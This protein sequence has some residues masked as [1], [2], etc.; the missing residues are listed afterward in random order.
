[1]K[2]YKALVD[3]FGLFQDRKNEFAR[4]EDYDSKKREFKFGLM[5]F[6]IEIPESH[7]QG[8]LILCMWQT[9]MVK[10]ING[11]EHPLF[12]GETG[13]FIYKPGT[14]SLKEEFRTADNIRMWEGYQE[15]RGGNNQHLS[16]FHKLKPKITINYFSDFLCFFKVVFGIYKIFVRYRFPNSYVDF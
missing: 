5:D 14:M 16:F 1:M 3:R 7:N 4:A 8:E 15:E 6:A 2:T 9:I 13:Q 10:D 12:N 11:N